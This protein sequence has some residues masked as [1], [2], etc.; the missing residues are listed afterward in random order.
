[1]AATVY[2]IR[3]KDLCPIAE[4][5]LSV[6]VHRL[7]LA[8]VSEEHRI[9]AVETSTQLLNLVTSSAAPL[10]TSTVLA[11]TPGGFPGQQP[12]HIQFR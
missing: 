3:T 12:S 8:A 1:M 11:S 10:E 5:E 9:Q 2:S 6:L 7:K 4:D